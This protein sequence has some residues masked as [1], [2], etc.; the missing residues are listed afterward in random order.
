MPSPYNPRCILLSDKEGGMTAVSEVSAL[1]RLAEYPV[2]HQFLERW[3]PR[4]LSGADIPQDQLMTLFEAARWAPSDNNNQ[5]WRFLYARRINA[6]W[7]LYL[8]LLTPNN[9]RWARHASVLAVIVSLK[10]F[11][12]NG[13]LSRTHSFDA[14]AAWMC[15]A[16]QASK[17]GLL[18][19][20][21]AGLDY[22]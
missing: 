19:H 20:A 4:A 18:A 13:K 17:Q 3:S 6:Y 22:D 8:D 10:V 11:E 2:D 5:P 9:Q 15:L 12:K 14:G 7:P 1:P 16:L 21:M